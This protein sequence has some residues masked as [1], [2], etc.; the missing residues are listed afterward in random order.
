VLSFEGVGARGNRRFGA[1]AFELAIPL[2]ATLH[3]VTLHGTSPLSS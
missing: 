3:T 1:F 2:R